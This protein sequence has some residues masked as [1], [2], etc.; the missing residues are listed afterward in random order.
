MFGFNHHAIFKM[1]IYFASTAV[2][3][4][5]NPQEVQINVYLLKYIFTE[6]VWTA[7]K[8]SFVATI[9]FRLAQYKVLCSILHNVRWPVYQHAS[10]IMQHG[11]L[12]RRECAWKLSFSYFFLFFCVVVWTCHNF[13]TSLVRVSSLVMAGQTKTHSFPRNVYLKEGRCYS[14]WWDQ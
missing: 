6:R 10:T 8:C 7:K 2:R 5:L 14:R 3:C 1:V 9:R 11:M 4:H 13:C 12:R